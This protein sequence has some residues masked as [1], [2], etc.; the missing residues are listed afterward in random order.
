MLTQ[1]T[2]VYTWHYIG[3]DAENRYIVAFSM[4]GIFHYTVFCCIK[5]KHHFAKPTF[6]TWT[7]K[8]LSFQ[9]GCY[10]VP[11]GTIGFS[12]RW[13]DKVGVF[14]DVKMWI[15]TKMSVKRDF[16]FLS[17]PRFFIFISECVINAIFTLEIVIQ[18]WYF[19]DSELAVF[20]LNCVKIT[21]CWIRFNKHGW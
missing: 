4:C 14:A 17:W 20:T 3:A 8:I 16:K 18:T 2:D 11:A 19:R 10:K 13:Y 21:R 5:C 6:R 12:S 15:R 7:N 1:F 9:N